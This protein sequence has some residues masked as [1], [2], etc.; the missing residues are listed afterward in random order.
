MLLNQPIAPPAKIT[1]AELILY[2]TIVN[3]DTTNIPKVKKSI[4]E[5]IPNFILTTAINMREAIFIPSSIADTHEEFLNFGIMGF[6]ASTIKNAGKNIP[7]VLSTAPGIPPSRYPTNVAVV[8]TGP[9]VNCPTATASRSCS[10]V[11]LPN[12]STNSDSKNAKST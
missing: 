1:H 10:V 6:I 12:L 5:V 7:T 3:K 8:N 4:K 9:G 11:K 2:L